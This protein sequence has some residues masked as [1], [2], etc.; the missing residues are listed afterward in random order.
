MAEQKLTLAKELIAHFKPETHSTFF[1]KTG[2]V[3]QSR[4]FLI[5]H[6]CFTMPIFHLGQPKIIQCVYGFKCFQTLTLFNLITDSIYYSKI[7]LIGIL[8]FA[9]C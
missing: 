3:K 7:L 8:N 5:G 2:I 6:D 9:I 4:R 1:T